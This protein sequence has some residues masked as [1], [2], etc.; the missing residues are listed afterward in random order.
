MRAEE[1]PRIQAWVSG[2]ANALFILGCSRERV[3]DVLSEIGYASK[4]IREIKRLYVA[5]IRQHPPETDPVRF[6]EIREAMESAIAVINEMA[7]CVEWVK[8]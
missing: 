2:L 3:T 7:D 8:R 4:V 5:G 6:Q 1:D